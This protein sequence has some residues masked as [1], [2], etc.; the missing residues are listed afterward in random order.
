MHASPR[1][2]DSMKTPMGLLS[3]LGLAVGG[4]A[5]VLCASAW[6][7][8][9]DQ[10]FVRSASTANQFEI[11]SS[12]LALQNSQNDDVRDFAQHMIDDHTQ[13]GNRL[14]SVISFSSAKIHEP[15]L[16]LKPDQQKML[17]KLTDL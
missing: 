8:T 1:L 15:T 16:S 10:D 12:R 7:A 3:S 2:N 4:I 14:K 13:I 5:L 6:A 17:D 9:S 11:S